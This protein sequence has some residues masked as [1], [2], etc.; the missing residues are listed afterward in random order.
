MTNYRAPADLPTRVLIRKQTF[1]AGNTAHAQTPYDVCAASTGRPIYHNP[2]PSHSKYHLYA[3]SIP[4]NVATQERSPNPQRSDPRA[5]RAR[6]LPQ[7][8]YQR[9]C[10]SIATPSGRARTGLATEVRWWPS[11]C[12]R[13]TGDEHDP[14]TPVA[15]SEGHVQRNKQRQVDGMSPAVMPRW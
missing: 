14:L 5:N 12:Q 15:R 6:R 4:P 7:T 8:E 1:T 10:H 3:Q 2:N 13:R 9:T 11:W